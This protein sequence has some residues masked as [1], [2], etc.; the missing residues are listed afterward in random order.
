MWRELQSN[1]SD[2][3]TLYS[4]M[5]GG[6][7]QIFERVIS[8]LGYS[9]F[10]ELILRL[11]TS[12]VLK[13]SEI[14]L[15]KDDPIIKELELDKT[16]IKKYLGQ[17]PEEEEE[18]GIDVDRVADVLRTELNQLGVTTKLRDCVV[19]ML[20]DPYTGY[21]DLFT[22][23][24]STTKRK[25]LAELFRVLNFAGFRMSY[26]FIDQLD[27]MF[28]NVYKTMQKNKV[29]QELRQFANETL[30][31]VSIATTTYPDLT[32]IF[33]SQYPH[34]TAALPITKMRI[35]TVDRLN[36]QQAKTMTAKY[37]ETVKTSDSIPGLYPFSEQ[38]IDFV[39]D[40]K[41]GLPRD[42]LVEFHDL[43]DY[44][45][46]QNAKI[47]DIDFV[48]KYYE[49]IAEEKKEVEP[50]EEVVETKTKKTAVKVKFGDIT[51]TK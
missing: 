30:G 16:A 18:K 43:L 28:R 10:S 40:Q 27:F 37:L 33:V 22:K 39:R 35:I 38:A 15:E 14:F 34:L 6:F 23:I 47:I 41:D 13:N 44:A 25:A 45:I 9:F 21:N 3:V 17:P 8:Q 51:D 12:V 19:K 29:V 20:I 26:L 36:S 46:E 5:M 11:A 32:P 4:E 31:Y 1:R 24:S 2:V 50:T 49:E 42:M 48:K 7:P